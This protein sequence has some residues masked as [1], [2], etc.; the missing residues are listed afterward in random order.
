MHPETLRWKGKLKAMYLRHEELVNEMI[1]RG[2][3][4]KSPLDKRRAT[5]KSIQDIF[6]HTPTEQI[7]ILKN[8][9]CNCKVE[10]FLFT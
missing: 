8:K 9:N 10:G 1:S 3:V 6:I 5:G 2:Y 7:E 4:H